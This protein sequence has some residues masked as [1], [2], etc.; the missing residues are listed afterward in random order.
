MA[1]TDRLPVQRPGSQEPFDAAREAHIDRTNRLS[2]GIVRFFLLLAVI[3]HAAASVFVISTLW[4]H[5]TALT[6]G[7]GAMVI[8]AL[9]IMWLRM[10]EFERFR[11]ASPQTTQRFR[12]PE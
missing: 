11:P 2:V 8:S 3:F 4:V 9:W 6:T 7:I 10:V 12:K 1:N 5:T